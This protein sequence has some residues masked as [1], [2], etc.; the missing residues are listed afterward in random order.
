ML[1]LKNREYAYARW[2]IFGNVLLFIPLG[3]LVGITIGGEKEVFLH[4][5]LDSFFS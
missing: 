4:L 1:S 2:N 5:G 3:L